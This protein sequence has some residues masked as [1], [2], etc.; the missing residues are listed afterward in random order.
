MVQIRYKQIQVISST[1]GNGHP[2]FID[3]NPYNGAL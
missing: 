1:M 3:V 2:T